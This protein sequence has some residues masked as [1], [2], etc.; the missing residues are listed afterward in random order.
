MLDAPE[1]CEEIEDDCATSP[2]LGD[3]QDNDCDGIVD[4]G[5]GCDYNGLMR[6]VCVD[7]AISQTLQ[8]CA[9]PRDYVDD[10]RGQCDGL[11]NDCD[12]QVDE[13]CLCNVDGSSAGVCALGR[14]VET[15]ACAPPVLYSLQESSCDGYDNDCD[16]MV[17]EGCEK[18]TFQ[19]SLI[20]VCAHGRQV[21]DP[22]TGSLVCAPPMNYA[23]DEDDCATD[24]FAGD[25]V[26][27]DCDGQVD[28]G[29]ACNYGDESRGVCSRGRLVENSCSPPSEYKL[30][31]SNSVCDGLD[32]DCDGY[33]D[34]GCV[35]PMGQ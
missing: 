21:M 24:P 35:M 3:R 29:C 12:G 30:D 25:N 26:D 13:G 16:G 10:E 31:E 22:D 1:V 23:G 6:G 7:G 8:E 11:D 34:N 9:L 17:D 5:C 19:G 33:V 28:E 2:L 32:N 15:G 18:C 20:G 4:E 27:N 14:F